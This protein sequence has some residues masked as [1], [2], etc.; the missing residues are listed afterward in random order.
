ML[1]L[2]EDSEVS[3]AEKRGLRFPGTGWFRPP[4]GRQVTLC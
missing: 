3:A 4:W 1:N 2:A